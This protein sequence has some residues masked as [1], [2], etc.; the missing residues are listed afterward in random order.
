MYADSIHV[1]LDLW[2]NVENAHFLCCQIDL[3][4]QKILTEKEREWEEEEE[5]SDSNLV[6]DLLELT[7][8]DRH[9]GVGGRLLELEP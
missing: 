7:F 3:L 5:R 9:L 2:L 8:P 1:G 6:I 4:P